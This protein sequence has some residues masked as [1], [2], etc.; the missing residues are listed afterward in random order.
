MRS[1]NRATWRRRV[2]PAALVL[3]AL[4][5]CASSSAVKKVS[6]DSRLADLRL[7]ELNRSSE[8]L[9]KELAAIR[10]EI[11]VVRAEMESLRQREE[12]RR[13]EALEPL[14]KRLATTE[15]RL[16]GLAGT[17][18]GVEMSVGGLADQVARMEAV[19]GTATT[20]RDGRASKGGARAPAPPLSADELFT[21]AM[22]SFKQGELGQAVL[23]FEEVVAKYP[24]HALAGFA[25]FWIGEAYYNAREYQHATVEYRKAVDVAPRGEKA[26]DALFKLGLA[27]RALKRPDRA[28]E[29]WTQLL[30]DFPQSDAAQKARTALR[31]ASRAAK[32]GASAD[33]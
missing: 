14:D 30:R 13:R 22:E 4:T 17:I 21:R 25:Q 29:V 28:R 3:L 6:E 18:R 1:G 5:G 12:M 27:H 16:D 9:R 24:A 15:K 20:R 2:A 26:P 32:P 10:T 11:D 7:M 19:P 8:E 33:R 31:E 23:D